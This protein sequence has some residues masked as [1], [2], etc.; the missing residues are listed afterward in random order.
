MAVLYKKLLPTL[1]ETQ[2]VEKSA[3]ASEPSCSLQDRRLPGPPAKP[4]R[5]NALGPELSCSLQDFVRGAS[6]RVA[7]RLHRQGALFEARQ[8]IEVRNRTEANYQVI[9]RER[10]PMMIESVRNNN[11]LLGKIDGFHFA[12][13]KGFL[14]QKC[15]RSLLHSLSSSYTLGPKKV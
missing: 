8:S 2:P 6:D 4:R 14:S 12:G 7:K 13:E 15:N 5:D 9:V 11:L 10:V 1:R 3:V